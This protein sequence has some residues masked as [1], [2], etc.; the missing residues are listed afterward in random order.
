MGDM[1]DGASF[2]DIGADCYAGR[3]GIRDDGLAT[4]GS[5]G[6][7]NQ[8]EKNKMKKEFRESHDG[9][10]GTVPPISGLTRPLDI[11]PK[12]RPIC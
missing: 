9:K 7:R 8:S 10:I 11:M 3:D 5:S 4:M 6:F 12:S 2:A 1:I